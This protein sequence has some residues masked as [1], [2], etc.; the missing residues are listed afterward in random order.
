M[1]WIISLDSDIATSY[2]ERY[3]FYPTLILMKLHSLRISL[4]YKLVRYSISSTVISLY[5]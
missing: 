2:K 1:K 4:I 5:A 3:A